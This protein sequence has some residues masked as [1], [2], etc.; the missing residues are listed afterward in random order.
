MEVH[1]DGTWSYDE[2]T[3]LVIPDRAEPFL[4]VDRHH[5]HKVDEPTPNPLAR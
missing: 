1:G 5:L 3:T 4:H 2:T